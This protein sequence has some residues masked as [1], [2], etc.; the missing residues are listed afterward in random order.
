[1]RSP[2]PEWAETVEL[3][4]SSIEVTEREYTGERRANA[5]ILISPEQQLLAPTG[6]VVRR[7]HCAPDAVFESGS[8]A[9]TL[10]NFP[11]IGL[12]SDPPMW[13]DLARE[14]RGDDVTALQAELA[15]LGFFTAEPNGVFGAST[16]LALRELWREIGPTNSTQQTL[17]LSQLL[18]MNSPSAIIT[19]CHAH[20][21]DTVTPGTPLLTL[22]GS[23]QGLQVDTLGLEDPSAL[24]VTAPGLQDVATPLPADGLVTDRAFLD[25]FTELHMFQQARTDGLDTVSVTTRLATPLQLTA[26][27]PSSLYD[28]AGREGCVIADG[29]PTPVTVRGSELGQSLIASAGP[30]RS[31]VIAP[32][33]PPPC[34]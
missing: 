11:L 13:R 27:P 6:G 26:V 7:S 34:R 10:D 29:S 23:L 5:D 9:F 4:G 12:Y 22:G 16:G 31:V 15:R 20:V 14:A 32:V 2:T 28:L 8:A 18:W 17:P 19:E 25:A 24:V 3:A 30:I 21:G 1:F 33:D